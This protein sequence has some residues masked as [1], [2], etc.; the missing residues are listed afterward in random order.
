ISDGMPGMSVW[1]L[2]SVDAWFILGGGPVL[3]SGDGGTTPV[4]VAHLRLGTR[5][6]GLYLLDRVVPQLLDGGTPASGSPTPAWSARSLVPLARDCLD[7]RRLRDARRDGAA[8]LCL[9]GFRRTP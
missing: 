9:C 1:P 7:R 5:A 6:R 8:A 4:C 2:I 3:C